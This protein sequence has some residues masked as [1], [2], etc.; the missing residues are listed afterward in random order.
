MTAALV[1]ALLV[2][3]PKSEPTCS[4]GVGFIQTTCTA[5]VRLHVASNLPRSEVGCRGPIFRM[6]IGGLPIR[7]RGRL[8]AI[9]TGVSGIGKIDPAANYEPTCIR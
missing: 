6:H 1:L 3:Q 9:A 8:G 2:A 4:A 5:I 7:F